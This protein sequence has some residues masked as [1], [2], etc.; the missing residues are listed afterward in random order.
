MAET[1]SAAPTPDDTST[2]HPRSRSLTQPDPREPKSVADALFQ[3]PYSFDFYQAVRL[4][5]WLNNHAPEGERAAEPVRFSARLS[6]ETPAGDIYDLKRPQ[7][8]R[9]REDGRPEGVIPAQMVT[10]FFDSPALQKQ[11]AG[12]TR[13]DSAPGLARVGPPQRQA[14]VRGLDVTLE[15]DEDMYV[16][17]GIY[18]LASVLE[19]FLGLYCSINSFTRLTITSVQR[20]KPLANFKPRSGSAI[21]A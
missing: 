9:V 8:G 18:L 15:F 1:P 6:L 16:G 7:P 12:I 5:H 17:G 2:T 21:V 13:V 10:N 14:F 11:I 3:R 19:R 4:L 20:E